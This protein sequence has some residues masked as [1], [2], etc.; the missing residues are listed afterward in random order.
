[1]IGSTSAT[2]SGWRW[3]ATPARTPTG[4]SAASTASTQANG[5]SCS[6]AATFPEQPDPQPGEAGIEERL[7]TEG[8]D[9]NGPVL[10]ADV[11]GAS[12]GHDQRRPDRVPGVREHEDGARGVDVTTHVRRQTPDQQTGRDEQRHE[13]RRRQESIGMSTSWLGTV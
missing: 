13:R 7:H 4:A 1:M 6:F 10:E 3:P 11:P 5:R 9:E 2:A 8:Q 12:S